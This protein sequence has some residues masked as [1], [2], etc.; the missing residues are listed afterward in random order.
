MKVCGMLPKWNYRLFVPKTF[1]TQDLSFPRTKGPYGELSFPRNESFREL[2]FPE[3]ESSWELSFLGPFVPGNFRSHY[4]IGLVAALLCVLNYCTTLSV[5]PHVLS[6]LIRPSGRLHRSRQTRARHFGTWDGT[7]RHLEQDSSALRS[8]LSLGHFG[9]S[10][11]LS[12]QFGPTRLVPKCPGSEVS[13]VRS[14]RN[15]R[16]WLYPYDVDSIVNFSA[17]VVRRPT[18]FR[19]PSVCLWCAYNGVT[20]HK[21]LEVGLMSVSLS[22]GIV[23][24]L[25][26]LI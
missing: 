23:T 8:E 24:S 1:R 9:T 3:N 13:W 10:T 6:L 16:L 25:C 15:S 4:P 5:I 12:G 14:V 26:I 11:D 21:T 7:V 2:S 19:C 22:T 18:C 20:A 17:N